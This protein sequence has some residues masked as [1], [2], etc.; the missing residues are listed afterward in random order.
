MELRHL[1]YF[2]AVAEDLN[3]RS[4]ADRLHVSHPTLS[5]QIRDLEYELG[6][7]LFERNTVSVWLTKAGKRFYTDARDILS[8]ADQ[9]KADAKTAAEN[10]NLLVLASASPFWEAVMHA[11]LKRF[12]QRHPEIEIR[13]VE[14]KPWNQIAALSSGKFDVGFVN[15]SDK[16]GHASIESKLLINSPFGVVLSLDHAL[17]SRK[18]V[19]CE[20]L[21]DEKFLVLGTG[22]TSRHVKDIRDAMPKGTVQ[23]KRIKFVGGIDSLVTMIASN[24]GIS[25]LPQ[26]FVESRKNSIAFIPLEN[27]RKEVMFQL[28]AAWRKNDPSKS[29]KLLTDMIGETI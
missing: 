7:R 11:L 9:A 2:V 10:D 18:S 27:P 24:Q 23:G 12:T 16:K 25:F 21:K 20:D 8:R 6:V 19:C 26:T 5:K 28:W 22:R 1:R 4:A 3:F 14:M 17:A 29:L 15:D 13:M